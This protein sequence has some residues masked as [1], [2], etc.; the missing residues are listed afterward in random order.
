MLSADP[1]L[2]TVTRANRRLAPDDSNDAGLKGGRARLA[3]ITMTLAR[4]DSEAAML[5]KALRV[6]DQLGLPIF[7]GEG[8]SPETFLQGIRRLPNV[9]VCPM[10]PGKKTTLVR[11]IQAAVARAQSVDPQFLLYTEPDKQQFFRRGARRLADSVALGD[12]QAGLVIASRTSRAFKTFPSGQQA[13]ETLMNRIASEALRIQADYT[14]GPM[15]INNRLARYVSLIP[16]N[17][18]WGWRFYL[19]AIAR[20]LRMPIEVFPVTTGCPRSQRGED[21]RASREYRLRQLVQNVT[22]LANGWT[23]LLDQPLDLQA[24]LVEAA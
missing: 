10:A 9:K 24:T 20:Q 5:L 4:N 7:V 22:G 16:K 13:A 3:V 23:S 17:L 6:L 1:T 18:S 14:Y 8:G 19:M 2:R 12:P 21:D 11:Q 15:L